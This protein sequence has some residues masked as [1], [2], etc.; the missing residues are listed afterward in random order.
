MS[1]SGPLSK[2]IAEALR[3]WLP[4]C[5]QH[6]K[7]YFTPEDIE[8]GR[9]W[10][11][12]IARELERAN[13][14]IICLTPDNIE[15]PWI[16]F[17]AGA[18]SKSLAKSKVCPL[19]FNIQP[20][21]VVGPLSA[22]QAAE[23][24]QE[25]FKSLITDINETAGDERLNQT[26]LENSFQKWW[27]DLK[28]EIDDILASYQDVE[29]KEKRPSRDILEEI[30]EL[31]RRNARNQENEGI[32]V[33]ALLKLGHAIETL[34]SQIDWRQVDPLTLGI[35]RQALQ[36][37]SSQPGLPALVREKLTVLNKTESCHEDDDSSILDE[38]EIPF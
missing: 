19:L 32:P 1:W 37:L 13:L 12:E 28:E 7:P 33:V 8:K 3:N 9:R 20:S 10:D 26:Y 35:L 34:G 6:V 30:L 27:P 14:G 2:E 18:L 21:E 25:D 24:I 38:E 31:T 17:E 29:V 4:L 36:G 11:T 15:R 23:F 5:L 16:L 22:F